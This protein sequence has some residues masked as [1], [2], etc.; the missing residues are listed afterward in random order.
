MLRVIDTSPRTEGYVGRA[1]D[2]PD[3]LRGHRVRNQ[4]CFSR[5]V[6]VDV[7]ILPSSYVAGCI[8]RSF[9][10]AG[11]GGAVII[12]PDIL[13]SRPNQLYWLTGG[14]RKLRRLDSVVGNGFAAETTTHVAVVYRNV[15]DFEA[16]YIRHFRA[17]TQWVL[18]TDPHFALAVSDCRRGIQW[19]HTRVCQVRHLVVR[20]DGQRCIS[21]GCCQITFGS[22]CFAVGPSRDIA[23]E[24]RKNVIG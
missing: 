13:F 6:F 10:V 14:F 17:E 19:F 11:D 15:I 9:E 23:G 5:F 1:G 20:L 7:G 2:V 21:H 22:V 18:A 24:L 4:W 3:I 16:Q 12:L 8:E